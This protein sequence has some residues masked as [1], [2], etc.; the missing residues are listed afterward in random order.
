MV[1][2]YSKEDYPKKRKDNNDWSVQ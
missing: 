2:T 1:K